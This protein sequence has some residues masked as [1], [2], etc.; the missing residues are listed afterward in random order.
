[1]KNKQTD[2]GKSELP[3]LKR[4]NY[5]NSNHIQ[6]IEKV[7]RQA[8]DEPCVA[9]Y[10]TEKT[11]DFVRRNSCGDICRFCYDVNLKLIFFSY[12]KCALPILAYHFA[13]NFNIFFL[14]KLIAPQTHTHTLVNIETFCS[15]AQLKERANSFKF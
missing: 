2:F 10:K 14:I 15:E 7:F 8:S 12:W 4:S 11:M 6:R 5:T 13:W 9:T 3:P 1:M